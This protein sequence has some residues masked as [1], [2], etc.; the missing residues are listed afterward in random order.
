MVAALLIRFQVIIGPLFLAFLLSYLLYPIVNWLYRTMKLSWRTSVGLTFFVIL[1]LLLGLLT[2]GGFGLI[3]QVQSLIG[4]VQ[5]S[6]NELPNIID[7]F[8]AWGVRF[9][10]NLSYL[11]L[12]DQA[13]SLGQN[14]LGRMGTL[15]ATVASSAATFVG[16]TFFVLVIAFFILAESGGLRKDILKIDIPGYSEDLR[17]LGEELGLIWNAF[18][19]GQIILFLLSVLIYFIALT[20]LGVRYALGLSLAAGFARFVPYLGPAINWMALALVSF[21]QPYKP[22]GLEPVYY[23]IIVLG[24]CFIIDQIFD[25]IVQ[26]RIM[27]KALRVH[28]A[29]VLVSAIIAA[30][31]IGLLGVVLAAPMLATVQML[32]IYIF[33]KML[34]L[35]PWPLRP[36]SPPPSPQPTWLPRLIAW[37]RTFYARLRKPKGV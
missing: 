37:C 20:L 25:N 3:N 18:L 5:T 36:A 19:R 33:R 31:L 8:V 16:L 23:T 24:I 21:F 35:D 11:D 15:L 17:R 34:D 29:A 6:L 26:P 2:L 7:N 13:L 14:L 12:T 22:F 28:P 32:G 9:N 27:A 1:L 10:L 4:F 30:N